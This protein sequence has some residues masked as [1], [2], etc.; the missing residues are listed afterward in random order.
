MRIFLFFAIIAIFA[1]AN[2]I[3][4]FNAS[5]VQTIT[6]EQN[7]SV[8]YEGEVYFNEDKAL[9]HYKTP[10]E[11]L[12]YIHPHTVTVIEPPLE[13]AIISSHNEMSR[14]RSL[15]ENWLENGEKEIEYDGIIYHITFKDGLPLRIDYLDTLENKV[16]IKLANIQT[17]KPIDKEYFNPQIPQEFDI[18]NY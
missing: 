17:K 15:L 1:Y 16:A 6:S 18:L 5:F 4:S 9:W 10:S 3:K 7:D 8:N 14:M 11:K 12:I 2:P 13:Q